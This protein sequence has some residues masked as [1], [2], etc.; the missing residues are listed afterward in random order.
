MNNELEKS[1][2]TNLKIVL[3]IL[4]RVSVALAGTAA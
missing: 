2:E 4:F 3:E 1:I